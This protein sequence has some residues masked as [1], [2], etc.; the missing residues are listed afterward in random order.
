MASWGI[1]TTILAPLPEIE[2][3]LAH[4]LSL[5]ADR[6]FLHLDAPDPEQ[7]AA[8][9]GHDR[10]EVIAC[11]E[12]YWA[13]QTGTRPANQEARQAANMQR[14]Y[15]TSPLDWLGHI[16]GDEFIW[17][18]RPVAAVLDDL[19]A[20]QP[21]LRLRPWEALHSP[22]MDDDIF[23]ARWF[24]GPIQAARKPKLHFQV[25]S[26][27]HDILPQGMLSH[28]AGKCLFRTR[29]PG[30][31][32]RLHG[33]E[34]DG[35]RLYAGGFSDEIHLLHFHAQN[36][37]QWKAQ[38]PQRLAAGAYRFNAAL[39]GLLTEATPEEIDMFYHHVM[40]PGPTLI[41]D[42]ARRGIVLRAELGLRAK[43]AALRSGQI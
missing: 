1:V 7:I 26:P 39:T 33:A 20:D 13:R 10:V 32:P 21:I 24:R 43:V 19:P 4:H 37:A 34:Q 28:S 41:E 38:L 6:I 18:D 5:G 2:A 3:F 12:D 9:S 36:P 22:A 35:E 23:T 30:L 16:D 27:F 8:L 11:T 25:F 17:P 31:S 15:D 42:W 29:Q 40:A 14:V